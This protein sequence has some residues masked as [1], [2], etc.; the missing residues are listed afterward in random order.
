[1]AGDGEVDDLIGILWHP[2]RGKELDARSSATLRRGRG[3]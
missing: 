1:M 2:R 3:R